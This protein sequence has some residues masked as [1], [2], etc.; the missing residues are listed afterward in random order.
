MIHLERKRFLWDDKLF[1][2]MSLVNYGDH[3]VTVPLEI[4]FGA[5][6]RDIFEVRGAKP[7]GAARCSRR[8]ADGRVVT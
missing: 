4:E 6:F 1:E 7:A 3:D 8:G 2:R 5:D